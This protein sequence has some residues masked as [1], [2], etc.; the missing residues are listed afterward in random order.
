MRPIPKQ[1]R[2]QLADEPRMKRCLLRGYD[3][4]AGKL[5]WNHAWVYSGR[6]IN[7]RWGIALL[8]VF[9][10]RLAHSNKIVKRYVQELLLQEMTDEELADAQKKYPR[11]DWV[12]ERKRFDLSVVV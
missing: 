6:Q 2:E 9:H 10:H 7:E 1:L 4:S 3:C 12:G 5:E 11:F 8:C